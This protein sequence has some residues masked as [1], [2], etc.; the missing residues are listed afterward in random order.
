MYKIV[1]PPAF[2]RATSHRQF[3][4]A[5]LTVAFDYYDE[6][7]HE[8]KTFAVSF[9]P[10]EDGCSSRWTEAG[11]ADCDVRI[12]CCLADMSSLLMGSCRFSSMMRLGAFSLSDGRFCNILDD[13]F[14]CRQKPWTNTDY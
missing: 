8:D 14:Y 4:A 5:E 2:V 12:K 11:G 1:D 9:K 6:L 13:L 3:P 7:A 10:S